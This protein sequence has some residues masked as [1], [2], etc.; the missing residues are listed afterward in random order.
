MGWF[1]SVYLG[2]NGDPGRT[3]TCNLLI[4]SQLL[5]PVELRNRKAV[6]TENF[7][8]PVFEYSGWDQ[9]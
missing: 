2:R 1:L 9:T 6:I 3:R 7:L 8:R 5:Y 4:I